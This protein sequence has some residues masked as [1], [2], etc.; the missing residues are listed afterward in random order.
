[1]ET[2]EL[3]CT[4]RPSLAVG[5]GAMASGCFVF[6]LSFQNQLVNKLKGYHY[7]IGETFFREDCWKAPVVNW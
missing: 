5:V 1:M 3:R 7:L 4:I 2:K 6:C